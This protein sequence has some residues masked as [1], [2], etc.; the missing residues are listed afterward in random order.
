MAEWTATMVTV[1]SAAMGVAKDGSQNLGDND[2][3]DTQGK[4]SG[5]ES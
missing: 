1:G 5:S 4:L 3:M 2:G